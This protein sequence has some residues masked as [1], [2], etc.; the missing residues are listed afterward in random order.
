VPFVSRCRAIRARI[1]ASNP[2]SVDVRKRPAELRRPFHLSCSR[3]SWCCTAPRSWRVRDAEVGV[4]QKTVLADFFSES[5]RF[6]NTPH[7]ACMTPKRGVG[8]SS[9]GASRALGHRPESCAHPSS[10]FALHG[11]LKRHGSGVAAPDSTSAGSLPR[12]L[13][14]SPEEVRSCLKTSSVMM[15]KL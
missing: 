13:P 11:P 14:F 4:L 3:P 5:S 2:G 1:R 9:Q 7:D 12:C 6:T 15:S 10:P 8:S